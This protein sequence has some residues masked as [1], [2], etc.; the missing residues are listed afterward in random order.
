MAE[1][2][3]STPERRPE[4]STCCQ[5][6]HIS[7]C[8]LS[9]PPPLLRRILDSDNAE[10]KEFCTN[11]CQYNMALA[12]TSLGVSE[13]TNVNRHRGWV[14]RVQ[15]ELCHLIGSLRPNEGKPPSYAQLYIYDP[16][17]ALAQRMNRNDDLCSSTM[18]SLQT[19]LLDHHQYSKK[20][21]HAYEILQ[22]YPEVSDANIRLRVR[23]YNLP[24]SDKVAAILPED[25]TAPEW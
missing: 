1:K 9:P 13:D 25:G 2:V 10:A 18:K 24:S 21:K 23:P 16:Q 3:S 17:L 14:F 8:C 12:F 11:I 15:G 19:M 20:F 5:R 4:F 22:N 7:L 6:G